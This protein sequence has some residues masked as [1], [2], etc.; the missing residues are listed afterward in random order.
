LRSVVVLAAVLLVVAAGCGYDEGRD[1]PPVVDAATPPGAR[2]VGA[3][4][5]SPGLIER[6][7]HACTFLTPGSPSRVVAQVATA[8][9]S[10]GFAVSC[11]G[12]DA[13][14]ELRALRGSVHVL[15]EATGEGTVVLDESDPSVVNVS[16]SASSSPGG[17]PI[18]SGF[19][20][21]RLAA[22]RTEGAER[23]RAWIEGGVECAAPALRRQTLQGCVE[24]WNARGN[25][26][27]RSRARRDARRP[28]AEV[29][30]LAAGPSVARGCFVGFL[31]REGRYLTYESRWRDGRL[32]W[33]TPELGY[34]D[35]QGFDPEARLRAD[36]TLVP[37]PGAVA[38]WTS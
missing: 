30:L 25:E 29:F 27:A 19:V 15:A 37:I 20:A 7:S 1:L 26:A 13:V 18:P 38:P 35:G 17:R 24:G 22:L 16:T 8:L 14:A 2:L 10:E 23:E 12:D 6:P 31:A 5:G 4:G 34:H 36:G 28:G 3:C 11:Q 33:A 32:V 21:L 9:E